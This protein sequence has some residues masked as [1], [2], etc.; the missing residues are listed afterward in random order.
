[1]K[2]SKIKPYVETQKGDDLDSIFRQYHNVNIYRWPTPGGYT[3]FNVLVKKT[4]LERNWK[5]LAIFGIIGMIAYK[6]LI[7]DFQI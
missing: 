2:K 7:G 3:E 5:R 1:M 4:W 6:F